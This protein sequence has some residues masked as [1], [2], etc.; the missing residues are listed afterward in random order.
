MVDIFGNEIKSA[1][2]NGQPVK[3]IW[4]YGQKVWPTTPPEPEPVYSWKVKNWGTLY[5]RHG[6]DIWTD[7]KGNLYCDYSEIGIDSHLVLRNT[8]WVNKSSNYISNG[9]N[10]WHDN[11]KNT[12]YSDG[13]TQYELINGV[14]QNKSWNTIISSGDNVWKDNDGNVC[15]E[16]LTTNRPSIYGGF[17]LVN[18]SWV[19]SDRGLSAT[20]SSG[21]NIWHDN[22]GHIYM[23]SVYAGIHYELVD[24]RWRT[25]TW[26]GYKN[27][28][29]MYVWYGF[30]GQIFYSDKDKQYE[31]VNGVWVP[32]N[33]G[34]N[35]PQS[36]ADVWY[37]GGKIYYSRGDTQ[38]QLT[39]DE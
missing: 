18:G 15:Y 20:M 6:H 17:N 28:T 23:D 13:D 24:G 35:T 39:I 7:Y 37:N 21:Q 22:E 38:Y 30:N 27:I 10:V 9:Q 25:H 3:E 8:S 36:G 19:L 32:K 34:E 33:W 4:S 16:G 12:F 31:L 26:S 2:N 14:W 11:D 29:G 1:Y 5:P